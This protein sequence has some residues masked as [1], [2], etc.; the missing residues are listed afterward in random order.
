[1]RSASRNWMIPALFIGVLAIPQN[2]RALEIDVSVNSSAIAATTVGNLDFQLLAG[3]VAQPL[4]VTI[5]NFVP[6]TLTM[7]GIV[8]DGNATGGPLP[9]NVTMV[10]DPGFNAALQGVTFGASSGFTLRL[11]FSGAALTTPGTTGTTF[12]LSLVGPDP[13]PTL[14]PGIDPPHLEIVIPASGTGVPVITS[15][16]PGINA[17]VVPEPGTLMMGV[18][19][20]ATL[21][22]S[23]A[24]WLRIRFDR[25]HPVGGDSSE[26]LRP[27]EIPN[28]DTDSK[29]VPPPP[30][31]LSTHRASRN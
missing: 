30:E 28:F 6:T 16:Y 22:L 29:S 2:A 13:F 7:G 14:L 15:Y 17:V 4:S 27:N 20:L 23:R 9:T 8:L 19:G 31:R 11:N 10:N 24:R 21:L 3:G 25:R 26:V 5:S 12:S 18:A 1:M